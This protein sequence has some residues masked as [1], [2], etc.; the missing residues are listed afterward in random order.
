M[1]DFGFIK[2]QSHTNG[3]IKQVILSPT[4]RSNDKP[5]FVDGG[6]SNGFPVIDRHTV[7]V[8][9]LRGVFEPNRWICPSSNHSTK[10]TDEE[11]LVVLNQRVKLYMNQQNAK[12]F[13]RIILSSDEIALQRRYSQGYDDAKRFLMDHNLGTTN[14]IFVKV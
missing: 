1:A 10:Q 9:P 13:R 5:P 3:K 4:T 6:V 8:T 11:E 2:R 12:T 7:I 14:K